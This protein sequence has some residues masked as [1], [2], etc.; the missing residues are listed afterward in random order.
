MNSAEKEKNQ[1]PS[2]NFQEEAPKGKVPSGEHAVKQPEDEQYKK[3]E[4]DFEDIATKKE[5]QEQPVNPIKTP[6]SS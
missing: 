2:S 1:R 5:N 4:V 3:D 6:P